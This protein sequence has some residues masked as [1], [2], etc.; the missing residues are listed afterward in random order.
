[1]IASLTNC[2]AY[3]DDIVVYSS[4]SPDHL[5]ILT[6]LFKSLAEA[7]LTLNLSKLEFCKATVLY[8]GKQVGHGKVRVLQD[9]V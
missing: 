5:D 3:P 7:H 2:S 8:L 4:N 9:K 6:R 1:M